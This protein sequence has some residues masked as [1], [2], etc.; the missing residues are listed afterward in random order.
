MKKYLISIF[1]LIFLIILTLFSFIYS[2]KDPNS[3]QEVIFSI[4]RGK[5]FGEIA[6]DLEKEGLIWWGTLFKGYV[7]AT[8]KAD[9]LQAGT[10]LLSPSMNIPIIAQK[11]A[12]GDIVK[13]RITIPEGFDAEQIYQRIKNITK[14]DLA[15]LKKY[16]G[17]LFPDTYEFIYGMTTEEV[18]KMMTDN[19]N[20]RTAHLEITPEIIIMASILEREVKTREEKELAAGVLWKRLR[21]GMPLQ[22]CAERWTYEN[23]GLPP[24]PICNPGLESI[25]AALYPKDSPYWYYISR[26]DG[27]TIFQRTLEEH[28]Y[29]KFKY[30]R[31]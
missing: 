16:E 30:L 4:P 26:P 21:V 6:S 15:S 8:G 12:I 29:A 5:G 23:L 13:A 27:V 9:N 10:Y 24:R 19:F 18:I 11:L 7:L 22:V 17:Y 14:V 20:K 2:P 25:E 1:L 31:R 3:E 28:N